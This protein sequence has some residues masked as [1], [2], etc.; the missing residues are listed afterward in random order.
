[1]CSETSQ[2]DSEAIWRCEGCGKPIHEN[3]PH[4]AGVDVELC[5]ECAPDWSDMLATPH[6]FMNADDTEMTREQVQALVDRHLAAGGS[7]T[8][9]L[10]S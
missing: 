5:P 6:L 1:M 3:D 4:H 7:L 8:D 10:V 2:T 9:K